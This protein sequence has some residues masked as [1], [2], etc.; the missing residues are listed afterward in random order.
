LFAAAAVLST[1]SPVSAQRSET[2]IE[3]SL[4]SGTL[5]HAWHTAPRVLVGF[6]AGFGLPQMNLTFHP[7]RN[8]VAGKPNFG[9]ILHVGTFVRTKL[10]ERFEIDAGVRGAAAGL[11]RCQVSDCW[12]E[13]FYGGYVQP[14]IGW[15]RIKLGSRLTAGWITAGED[16]TSEGRTFIVSLTPLL[17]RGTLAR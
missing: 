14:M 3:A 4:F 11:W 10:S 2:T 17:V 9:E 13:L 5:G 8:P 1:V 16:G 12:P 6:E 15:R 7:A